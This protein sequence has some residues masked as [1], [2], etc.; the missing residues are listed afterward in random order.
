VGVSSYL[1]VDLDVSGHDD[2]GDFTTGEGVLEAV[3]Q[4][5]GKRETF[6]QLV[7]TCGWLRGPVATE[8]VEHPVARGIESLEM[9]LDAASS[10]GEWM[11][12]ILLTRSNLQL[13]FQEKR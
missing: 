2:R 5:D 3:A 11:M 4:D 12:Y 10:H 6:S 9:F 13:E 7:W 8:L 1:S